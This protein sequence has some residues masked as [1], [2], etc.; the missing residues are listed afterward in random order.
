[1]YGL[2]L[3]TLGLAAGAALLRTAAVATLLLLAGCGEGDQR[4]TVTTAQ[5]CMKCH[6]GSLHDDYSGPGLEN[7]HPFP[8]AENLTCTQCHGGNP[9]GVDKEQ[10]HVPPP[11]QIGDRER[12][13]VNATAHFNRLTLAGI[14]KYADYTVDGVAWTAIDY[15]QFVNPGDLRVVTQGRACGQCHVS[16][17]ECTARSPLATSTG[18]F[19][20]AMFAAGADNLVAQNT[21]LYSDTAADLG[22]R[23]LTDPGW[24]LDPNVIGPVPLLVEMP[25]HSKRNVTAADQLNNNPNYLAPALVD[26]VDPATNRVLTN[27]PLHHLFMEQ[28][29]FTCGDCHLGSAGNNNRSGD[30]RSSGCTACHMPYSLGGRAGSRDPHVDRTEPLDPD[31]L[32]PPERSHVRSHQIRSVA[33]TLSNGHPQ[34]GIDD[35]TC[36]GCHQGSNRTVMQFWGIRLDQNEDVRNRRQYPMNPFSFRNTADDTRLYDPALGNREFNGRRANQYLEFEDYDNDAR[37]DT[38]P[39]VHHEAGMGCIDCHGSFELHGGDVNAGTSQPI[40]SRMEHG[41]AIR[42]EDCHGT[43]TAYAPTVAG[44]TYDGSAATLAVD[45]RGNPLRHVVRETD[46]SYWLTSRLDGRRHY[47]PQTRDVVVDSS[48]V[49]PVSGEPIYNRIGSYAMGRDDNDPSTGIGPQQ[50]GPHAGFSHLDT[51]DCAACHAAWTNTCMGC[52]LVGEFNGGNNFHNVTGERILFR[53]RF[54]DFVYQSPVPFQ[55]GV[56]P[57]NEIVQTS[58]N[59]KVFF[60][61]LDSTPELSKVFAFSDRRGRGNHPGTA[62]PSLS[63]NSM[64]AHSIRGRVTNTNEG[65]RYCV[66]CHLTTNSVGT[67]GTEYTAF[68]N[69]LATRNYAALDFDLLALHIGRN[70]GN[71]LDSPMWVHMVAGLGSGLFAFD[72]NGAPVND[73]DTFAGRKG[74]GGTAPKTAFPTR[75]GFIALDLDRIVE[76]NGVP[77]GS[78]NHSLRHPGTGPNLRDGSPDPT[79]AGPLGATLIQRLTDPTTGIVLDWWFDADAAPHGGVTTVAPGR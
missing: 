62:F 53:E 65:P 34:L 16:H 38:P 35:H 76:P 60:S 57:D 22:V 55:L 10:S 26:D 46:G 15:L 45:S 32:D 72:D 67:Y 73:L 56:G 61:Y 52:H 12:Q 8:G 4:A 13:R 1:M 21:G 70:P 3:R 49:H 79:M 41:V 37:D 63:H 42:C 28:V 59:T 47:V 31:D 20:G 51:M 11:P 75:V 5:S 14:D 2:H 25:V 74:A 43:A 29:S 6:N 64:L 77:N 44:T 33:R 19:S 69:A 23:D 24:S 18:I 78:N 7:P 17:A 40:V 58:S 50:S 9:A 68:R 36:A 39:D 71:R 48:K 66:A 30:Y 54:A 27:S